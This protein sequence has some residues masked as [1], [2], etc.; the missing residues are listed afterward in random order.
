MIDYTV[1]VT[2]P[3]GDV[4]NVVLVR[5]TAE[6]PEQAEHQVRA[7]YR[8]NHDELDPTIEVGLITEDW[9]AFVDQ[10]AFEARKPMV[11]PQ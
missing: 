9:A 1:V 7:Y 4:I 11:L 3:D 2:S 10:C 8:E 5:R 6:T